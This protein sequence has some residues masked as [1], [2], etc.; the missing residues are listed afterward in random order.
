[1]RPVAK[2]L[3]LDLLSTLREGAVMPVGVLVEAAE[4]FGISANNT[5]VAVARLLAGGQIQ[6]DERG[7]YRLGERSIAIGQRVRSWR[8]LD[9]RTRTW[10]GG[11]VG[12]QIVPTDRSG[13]RARARALRLLGMG[14]LAES[15][16]VRPDNLT[17]SVEA[18]R[19]ELC[20]LG[21]PQADLVYS[22]ADFDP[23]T[24]RRAR[25]LWDLGALRRG[26]RSWLAKIEDGAERLE[27]LDSERAMVESFLLG[28][29]ALRQLVG[30]PLLPDEICPSVERDQLLEA[31]RDYDRK[32]R[33]VWADL[34]KK[35]GV[36]YLR[37]P[38]DAANDGRRPRLAS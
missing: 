1:M 4:L 14:S 19:R 16:W 38:V 34:L 20:S 26:Y 11:W 36:P 3:I 7:C 2:S 9:R 35:W 22:L 37:A 8:G 25:A 12:V 27:T 30:D 15:L 21:L 31:M 28:G 17:G 6:R 29:E 23:D 5:R 24:D 13:R 18:V 33:L 10:S 32:G